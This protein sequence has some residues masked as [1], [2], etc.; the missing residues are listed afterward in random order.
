MNLLRHSYLKLAV[1][2]VVIAFGTLAAIAQTNSEESVNPMVKLTTSMGEI[3]LELYAEE[4]PV[5]V[6]NFLQYVNDGFYDG[7]IFHRVIP[8]FMIQGGGFNPG[9]AQKTEGEGIQN[10]ANNGLKNIEGTVALARTSDPHSAAAQFFIN[11]QDNL[12]LNHT[13]ESSSRTWGYAV[14]GRV[15]DGMS[16]VDEIRFVETTTTP[17]Y[18]NVP[19]VPVVIESVE[20][21]DG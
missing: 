10:E 1:M 9:M 7:T 3:T 18:S 16:V 15:T 5:S 4:A 12:N 6:A 11:T 14:F 2:A 20:I 17:P 21:I 13:G 8:G 19:K